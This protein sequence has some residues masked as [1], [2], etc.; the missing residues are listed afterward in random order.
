MRRLYLFEPFVLPYFDPARVIDI[1]AALSTQFEEV[2]DLR[3]GGDYVSG[4]GADERRT[5][6][7]GRDVRATEGGPARK[8]PTRR[9]R[10]GSFHAVESMP[11]FATATPRAAKGLNSAWNH[12][13]FETLTSET[14]RG[15]PSQMVEAFTQ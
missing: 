9:H 5:T 10:P 15:P 4:D 7:L 14:R 2:A 6:A 8:W 1:D 12:P 3:D 13:A 11:M